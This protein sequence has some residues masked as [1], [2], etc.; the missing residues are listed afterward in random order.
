MKLYTLKEV[1]EDILKHENL[2]ME[3]VPGMSPAFF[4]KLYSHKYERS[5]FAAGATKEQ[6]DAQ[7]DDFLTNGG[8]M[9]PEHDR[10]PG[11][12]PDNFVVY[13]ITLNDENHPCHFTYL[14]S[15]DTEDE[16]KA[17][18]ERNFD[19]ALIATVNKQD[20]MVTYHQTYLH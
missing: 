3:P 4:L 20:A 17:V 13:G 16:R 7:V 10:A 18:L 5:L 8:H 14:M 6:I 2:D 1:F 19:F 9:M 15:A 11:D 12:V